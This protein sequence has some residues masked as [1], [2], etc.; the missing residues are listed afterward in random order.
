MDMELTEAQ[1]HLMETARKFL[2]KECPPNAV[3]EEETTEAGFSPELWRKMA[4]L[5]WLGL[6][7]PEQ[8]GGFGL[9]QVDL[10]IL[11]RE[12]GRA[13]CPSPFIPSIVLAGGVIAHAGSE[14]QKSE[15]LPRIAGGQ[16]VVAFAFQEESVYWD[17]R[18]IK[19]RAAALDGGYAINGT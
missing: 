4:E 10:C 14:R 1:Q 13:I 8:H 2:Q 3:R 18:G 16:A 19:T 12:L 7:F 9:G 5:G 11:A 15:L 6:S 17:P